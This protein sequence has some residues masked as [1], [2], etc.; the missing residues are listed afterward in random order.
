MGIEYDNGIYCTSSRRVG[1]IIRERHTGKMIYGMNSDVR[2]TLQKWRKSMFVLNEKHTINKLS[3]YADYTFY[4]LYRNFS[5]RKI[6]VRL[7]KKRLI[8]CHRNINLLVLHHTQPT[9]SAVVTIPSVNAR[10][11]CHGSFIFCSPL[12]NDIWY[13]NNQYDF[14]WN[15]K[16]ISAYSIATPF[17]ERITITYVR[18]RMEKNVINFDLHILTTTTINNIER[19]T[20][21]SWF[22]LTNANSN[23]LSVQVTDDWFPAPLPLVSN[24]SAMNFEN[25]NKTWNTIAFL[26]SRDGNINE[27]DPTFSGSNILLNPNNYVK[28]QL[29]RKVLKTKTENESDSVRDRYYVCESTPMSSS[30]ANL[31]TLSQ[32]WVLAIIISSILV[33]V[34]A[35]SIMIWLYSKMQRQKRLTRQQ[36]LLYQR[37]Q[38]EDPQ[39]QL[40]Q[41]QEQE[42]TMQQLQPGR[43]QQ[44]VSQ[45]T[46]SQTDYLNSKPVSYEGDVFRRN[47]A[48]IKNNSFLSTPEA[49]LIADKFRQVMSSPSEEDSNLMTSTSSSSMTEN[50]STDKNS[51]SEE[52]EA[53]AV[54]RRQS[55]AS[56][57]NS[58][59]KASATMTKDEVGKDT[60]K[61]RLNF[62]KDSINIPHFSSEIYRE[63]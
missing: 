2:F 46:R 40:H 44:E 52:D 19:R 55:M 23:S 47:L 43:Q 3:N 21:K 59:S 13:H 28:F 7:V 37:K 27:Y 35:V 17:F 30:V 39:R 34:I 6:V 56:K 8:S 1:Y 36:S 45:L 63:D 38:H 32:K 24:T 16:L 25:G 50:N 49:K 51:S 62:D 4:E 11:V 29:V 33:V 5:S 53:V 22:N 9:Q 20:L 18:Y 41:Q 31:E 10:R 15:D 26:K 58:K 57:S 42:Q 48:P 14:I 12:S 61:H 60:L 54:N